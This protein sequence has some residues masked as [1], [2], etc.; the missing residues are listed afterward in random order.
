MALCYY[1]FLVDFYKINKTPNRYNIVKIEQN[2]LLL[3]YHPY[4]YDYVIK[5]FS[6]RELIF[7]NFEAHSNVG[8]KGSRWK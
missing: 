8:S 6:V 5:I 3:L 7:A 2:F 4:Y 1:Y